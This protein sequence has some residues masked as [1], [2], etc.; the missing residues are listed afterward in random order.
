MLDDQAGEHAAADD[1]PPA[2]SPGHTMWGE[3]LTRLIALCLA[4]FAV[5]ATLA[6]T[7]AIR[8]H[9]ISPFDEVTH[10]DY[11]YAVAHG[12]IPE[13]G[14]VISPAIR[15]DV[16]CRGSARRTVELKLCGQVPPAKGFAAGGQNYGYSHPPLYYAI[17]G[18][19]A[20]IADSFVG[21]QHF[22]L[23]ARL[24]GILW[25]FA[26]MLVLYL[27]LRRFSVR[28]PIAA[29]GAILLAATPTVFYPAATVTNDAAAALAGSLAVLLLARITVHGNLGW[30]LPAAFTLL[31]TA[32]KVLNA[33]PFLAIATVF[34]IIGL[35]EWRV[36]RARSLQ[37]LR[38][39]LGIVVGFVVVYIGW[40]V[41]QAHRGDP[42]Y[43]SPIAGISDR[44]IDGLPF[45]ELL[46]TSF[47]NLSLLSTG[48]VSPSLS[49]AWLAALLRLWGPLGLAAIA[50]LWALHKPWT[51]R[52]TLAACTV[53]GLLTVPLAV[54]LQV[55]INAGVYFPSVVP[56]YWASFVPLVIAAMALVADDKR[57]TKSIVAFTGL[58]VAVGLYTVL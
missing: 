44:P 23:L 46:S 16:V 21:G 30:K 47:S 24:T 25:L 26:A 36:D 10:A 40:T 57:L 33:L 39:A 43:A 54:E 53:T 12:R 5:A 37:F 51:P 58:C 7:A 6:G 56:R 41:F 35:R 18:G 4:M 9:G 31:A 49:N 17:T 42:N 28:W 38:I 29:C 52:F 50:A 11:A 34:G 27:A 14:S 55:Y 2:S 20:R 13:R 19:L 32:T 15:A 1:V 22:I 45:D 3:P 48:Y 8:V